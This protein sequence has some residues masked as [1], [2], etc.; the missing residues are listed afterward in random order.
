MRCTCPTGSRLE[1]PNEH[2]APLL[3]MMRWML[4]YALRSI[5]LFVEP[6]MIFKENARNTRRLR[7]S[8]IK[9]PFKINELNFSNLGTELCFRFLV[10]A[11]IETF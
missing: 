5:H 3:R 1:F 10:L 7:R 11:T 8:Q 4:A 9:Y 2:T 6:R